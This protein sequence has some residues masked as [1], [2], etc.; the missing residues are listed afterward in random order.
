MG[1]TLH[2]HGK[3][4]AY[5]KIN[6]KEYQFYFSDKKEADRK[7]IELDELALNTPI[8][9]KARLFNKDGRFIGFR[10][11]L[12]KRKGRK[13]SIIAKQQITGVNGIVR[14]SMTH[15]TNELTWRWIKTRWLNFHNLH[16]DKLIEL[17]DEIKL[18]RALYES[19][20]I[21]YK[22]EIKQKDEKK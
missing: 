19:D 18:A 15:Q 9:L 7:Q 14:D 22:I 17:S 4:R 21:K 3:Y 1:V 10:V 8:P 11:S 2:K 16:V 12:Y 20:I 13:Q 5:K 6:C